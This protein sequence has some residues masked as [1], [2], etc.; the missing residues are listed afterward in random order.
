[1]ELP[2]RSRKTTNHGRRDFLKML[3]LGGA[4][5]AV[6]L[7]GIKALGGVTK[8]K[9]GTLWATAQFKPDHKI[10]AADIVPDATL[11][12]LV[13]QHLDE[14]AKSMAPAVD[15]QIMEGVAKDRVVTMTVMG[16]Y[17][18]GHAK[19]MKLFGRVPKLG[20]IIEF[21]GRQ[22]R[23]TV[24]EVDSKNRRSTV[25]LDRPIEE[26]VADKAAVDVVGKYDDFLT[27]DPISR[28]NSSRELQHDEIV[29]SAAG[30]Q[31]TILVGEG[32]LDITENREF[33]FIMERGALDSVQPGVEWLDCRL[34][35]KMDSYT[36]DNPIDVIKAAG[37]E[38]FK[39]EFLM[40]GSHS[41]LPGC[42]A[43]TIDYSL[44]AG[45]FEVQ[46]QCG[47]VNA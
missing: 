6:G 28:H 40:E 16:D 30:L 24:I 18:Q 21:R 29:L 45:E 2:K 5:A 25:L 35:A 19:Q 1:M 17:D 36:G 7:T 44:Q 14:A 39:V 46:F 13:R 3:G 20:D 32:Q 26:A 42:Q 27:Y 12:K 8:P 4:S 23:Y 34:S 9:E 37:A 47:G 38:G 43:H 11:N 10:P 33:D 31:S 22:D 41:V 15:R